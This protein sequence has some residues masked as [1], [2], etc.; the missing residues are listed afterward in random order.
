M[1]LEGVQIIAL[2]TVAFIAAATLLGAFLQ[3]EKVNIRGTIAFGP[4]LAALGVLLRGLHGEGFL[5]VLSF[6]DAKGAGTA[7]ISG[8]AIA[9][10]ASIRL[11]ILRGITRRKTR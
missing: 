1:E 2:G 11:L 7:Y 8:L 4:V 6:Q 3:P 10:G 5:Y 9:L